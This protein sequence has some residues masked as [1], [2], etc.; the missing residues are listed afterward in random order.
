MLRKHTSIPKEKYITSNG[1]KNPSEKQSGVSKYGTIKTGKKALKV[2]FEHSDPETTTVEVQQNRS[3]SG[4]MSPRGIDSPR[5]RS[6]SLF[7]HKKQKKKKDTAEYS[8]L[9]PILEN[10]TVTQ[11]SQKYC[12]LFNDCLLIC[13]TKKHLSEFIPEL[14]IPLHDLFIKLPLSEKNADIPKENESFFLFNSEHSLLITPQSKLDFWFEKIQRCIDDNF[15]VNSKENEKSLHKN[16][17]SNDNLRLFSCRGYWLDPNSK[18]NLRF[19][20]KFKF[21]GIDLNEE[22]L[23]SKIHF[24]LQEESGFIIKKK[25][26]NFY[27]IFKFLWKMSC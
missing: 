12:F 25:T 15:G 23:K 22:I 10:F 16:D 6:Q 11:T 1:E 24:K 9:F 3:I 18:D 14:Y 20:K 7:V 19:V 13:D 8:I 26:F 4:E 17:E 2:Q 5:R 21:V 27:P